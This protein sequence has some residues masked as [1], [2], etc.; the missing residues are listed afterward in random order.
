MAEKFTL[1]K[2]KENMRKILAQPSPVE[3]PDI[4][5]QLLERIRG[6][7]VGPTLPRLPKLPRLP[8]V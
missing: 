2:H 7:G 6:R 3:R 4:K 1:D 8:R 5:T